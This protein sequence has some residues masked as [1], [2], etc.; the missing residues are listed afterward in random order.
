MKVLEFLFKPFYVFWNSI[1]FG[2]SNM[3][4]RA[5]ATIALVLFFLIR[6]ILNMILETDS[7]TLN[8]IVGLPIL[9]SYFAITIYIAFNDISFKK[10][11]HRNE[12]DRV[13]NIL[14]VIFY[15]L[16]SIGCFIVSGS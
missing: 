6:G 12:K 10:Y 5:I 15:L 13:I 2:L 3:E 4:Y 14:L 7:I 16:I 9:M 1:S 11:L 8:W